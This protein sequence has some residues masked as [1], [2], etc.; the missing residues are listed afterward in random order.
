M[1]CIELTVPPCELHSTHYVLCSSRLP[2]LSSLLCTP[3]LDSP[4]SVFHT[5][6]TVLSVLVLVLFISCSVSKL[7]AACAVL[8]TSYA[9]HC[10]LVYVH[11]LLTP[12]SI[13]KTSH[14]N[15]AKAQLHLSH[16]I[17]H[18][19]HTPSL[20]LYILICTPHDSFVM[21]SSPDSICTLQSTCPVLYTPSTIPSTVHPSYFICCSR[22]TCFIM[23]SLLPIPCVFFTVLF[24][25]FFIFLTPQSVTMLHSAYSLLY[26]SW[27]VHRV[28][29]N[30]LLYVIAYTLFYML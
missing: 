6:S 22:T 28:S 1:F 14:L 13:S 27:V 4:F 12:Y 9:V 15:Y 3:L 21:S 16:P 26:T 29:L 25:F 23:H 8:H 17:C 18:I 7:H 20:V 19:M 24:P 2:L 10:V 30:S 11:H 5:A